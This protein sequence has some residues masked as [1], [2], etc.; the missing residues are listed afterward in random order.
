MLLRDLLAV[1]ELH[2]TLLYEPAGGLERVL[3][4]VCASDL[5]HPMRY[6]SPGDLVVSGLVWRRSA[7]DSEVFV[8]ELVEAGAAALAAGDA[9]LGSIPDD[10]VECCRRHELPLVEVPS[11]VS[12]ADVIE[13]LVSAVSAERGARLT[14]SLRRQRQLLSDVA[15]GRS[16]AEMA[17]RLSHDIG[18]ECRVLTATGRLIVSGSSPLVAA[19]LDRV[20]EAFVTAQRLPT[21][22]RGETTHSLFTAGTG[23]DNRLTSW[24]VAVEGDVADWASDTVEAI[25]E[26]TSIAALDRFRSAEALRAIRHIAEEAVTLAD[27]GGSQLE[28]GA[29]LRQAGLD[30]GEPLIAVV[31][32]F[33]GRPDLQETIRTVLDDIAAGLGAPVVAMDSDGRAVALL[34]GAAGGVPAAVRA[35]L[36][37]LAPGVGGAPIAVG[38]STPSAPGALSGALDEARYSRRLAELRGE[39]VSVVSGDE[40]TSYV[41]LLATVPDEVRRAFANR[42]LGPVLEYDTRNG[43]GLLETLNVFVECSGSWSRASETLHLHINTVRYRIQRIEQLTGR[44]LSKLEDRVDVFL[45]LRSL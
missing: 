10:L 37:R 17:A 2:L 25:T 6:V 24:I 42:V 26:F 12:F 4:R 39:P 34:S 8:G 18:R 1:P 27:S 36:A 3:R 14:A 16:L 11:E 13:Y 45:A 30:P 43:G 31:A 29:R 21:V 28:I 33:A 40:V 7:A 20:T 19:D 41:L 5:L 44:D 38:I 9:F 23:F 15:A 32:D 22:T 35:A